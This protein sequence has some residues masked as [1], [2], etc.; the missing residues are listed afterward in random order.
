MKK[1]ILTLLLLSIAGCWFV[2]PVFSQST[3]ENP[4]EKEIHTASFKRHRL[5]FMWANTLVPAAKTAHDEE[6][7]L[8]FP[9][10]G[11]NYEYWFHH[12]FAVG[13]HNEFEMM[14]YVVEHGNDAELKRE[15]PFI[16]SIVLIYEPLKNL[17]F[18][19]GPGYEFE[20]N[21]SFFIVKMGAEY[22]FPLPKSFDLGF[23]FSYDNK[24]K[25]YDAWTF[26]LFIGKRIGK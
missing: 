19:I 4:V 22:V 10:W 26:G 25:L 20:A 1:K 16:S 6:S 15:Y 23:G 3:H 12:R 8:L 7:D 18:H 11:L 13:L 14:S 17:T 21:E 9:T 24:N 2:V 5:S